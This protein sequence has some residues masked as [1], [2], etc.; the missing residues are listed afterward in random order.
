MNVFLSL[1]NSIVQESS[2]CDQDTEGDEQP[3]RKKTP[4]GKWSR[5]RTGAWAAPAIK[6]NTKDNQSGRTL[7]HLEN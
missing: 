7:G 5:E 6:R 1:T 3:S 2:D 4:E